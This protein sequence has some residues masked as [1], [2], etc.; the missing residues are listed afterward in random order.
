MYRRMGQ[1][2][3]PRLMPTRRVTVAPV[4]RHEAVRRC[5]AAPPGSAGCFSASYRRSPSSTR[6]PGRTSTTNSPGPGHRSAWPR[7]GVSSS[8][9]SG[10]PSAE[11]RHVPSSRSAPWSWRSFSLRSSCAGCGRSTATR[12]TAVQTTAA[13]ATA[14]SSPRPTRPWYDLLAWSALPTVAPGVLDGALPRGWGSWRRPMPGRVLG[15]P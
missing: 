15:H 4:P 10:S 6:G 7:R 8:A 1:T 14:Y 5:P 9:G 3:P 11:G 12:P 13:L 2:G